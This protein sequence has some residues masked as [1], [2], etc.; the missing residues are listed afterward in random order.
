LTLGPFLDFALELAR[1]FEPDVDAG[2]V[3]TELDRLTLPWLAHGHRSLSPRR[4]A[5][6]LGMIVFGLAGFGAAKSDAEP[7]DFAIHKVL[8][9]RRG[10]PGLLGVVYHAVA[11]RLG[12]ITEPISAPNQLLWRVIDQHRPAGLDRAVIVDPG[13]NGEILDVDELLAN[14]DEGWLEAAGTRA[15]QR[16][17]LD[18][19]RQ[20]LT[21]RR[22]FG[23]ALVVLHRQCTSEPNNPTAF[24]E[25]GLLHRKL[26]APLAAIEDLETYLSLAPHASDVQEIS[27]TIDRVRDE[28]HRAPR[29]RAN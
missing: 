6:D 16:S 18:D 1:D 19:L 15:W 22:E 3:T 5:E 26:G 13:R 7:A 17:L 27:E 29:H 20:L 23:A 11:A 25:R 14:G 12:V 24:R 8:K 9:R 2:L 10:S 4:Q 28:L 21:R